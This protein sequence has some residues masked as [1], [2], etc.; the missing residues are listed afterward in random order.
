MS[1]KTNILVNQEIR[2]SYGYKA[3]EATTAILQGK[4]KFNGAENKFEAAHGEEN[5]LDAA[6]AEESSA[7]ARSQMAANM[8]VHVKGKANDC[9]EDKA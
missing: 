1:E 2:K 5:T 8:A 3:A 4:D 7:R 6:H 9:K